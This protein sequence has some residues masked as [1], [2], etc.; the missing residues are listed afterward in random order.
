MLVGSRVGAA[1][2]PLSAAFCKKAMVTNTISLSWRI[3]RA[4]KLASK[5]GNL[6]RV[7]E[8]VI[9]AQ[10]EGSGKVLFAGKVINVTR[11]LRKGHSYGEVTIVPLPEG[12][13]VKAESGSVKYEGTVT[14]KYLSPQTTHSQS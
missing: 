11:G 13:H 5:G 7:G 1:H 8:E 3:G 2:R 14:S 10:G 9:R 6:D 12:D 4:V